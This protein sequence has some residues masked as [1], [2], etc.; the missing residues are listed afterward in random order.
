[1]LTV[2]DLLA[3]E[4]LKLHA[5]A[6]L[7][8]AG[9]IIA[10]AHTVDLPDPWR[11]VSP[12]DLVMTTG[13]GLPADG[14]SQV[15]WLERLV[16]SNA[17]ALVVAP[18]ANAPALSQAMLDAADRLLFP[19]LHASFELEF[20]KLSHH[21][22]ESVLRAQRER[23]NASERLFQTYADALREVPDLDGRLSV[24][25]NTLDLNLAIEDTVSGDTIV[26]TTAIN[27]DTSEAMESIPIGGRTRANLVMSRRKKRTVEDSILVR[28]LVG[29]LGVELERLMI[30]RDMQRE[31]G[32]T[33]LRS[34]LE[35]ETDASLVRPM[36]ARRGL[37]GTLVS[38]AIKPDLSGPWHADDV[39]H[40]P[41]LQRTAPLL[42]ADAGLLLAITDDDTA[43]FEALCSSLG[44]G[45]KI[46][47]SGP[48][49][50]AAGFRESV[51]QARLSLTQALEIDSPMLRYGEAETGL[52]MAPKS[53]AEARALVGRYLGPLIEHDRT[54]GAALLPTLMTFL[55]NDGNWKATA[56]D[57]GVHR[58]TLVYR[59]KL[60]EQ[61]TGIKPTTTSGIARFW[62]AIQAGKSINLL[63]ASL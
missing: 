60:V 62:I 16:Q 43:L 31:E 2:Q 28:S 53:L 7:A 5:A 48:I 37:T 22:I 1:M 32:A 27:H 17:S 12:G 54:Q 6:G 21:V 63:Q 20:V 14:D 33:L 4:S 50:T 61:L 38:L 13:L 15:E 46:G 56:L 51:R 11:W 47:I 3:I 40:A 24:L 41:S 57:L 30:Q 42:L 19:L 29:L 39:H 26:A 55:E 52:I 35:L 8:G 25:G 34:L 36:L 23:F 9:R 59:L 44:P 49:V 18:Q 58:Q 10:W 45:T